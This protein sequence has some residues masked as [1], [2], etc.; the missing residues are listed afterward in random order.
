MQA[1]TAADV[2][3]AVRFAADRGLAV[4]A[5]G[6]GHAAGAHASLEGDGAG[7]DHRA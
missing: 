5:Q 4:T 6:P 1:E 3:A 7:A 2:A